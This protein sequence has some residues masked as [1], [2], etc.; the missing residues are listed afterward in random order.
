MIERS[1][2]HRNKKYSN[3]KNSIF[4]KIELFYFYKI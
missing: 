2:D 4:Y 3:I 1:E